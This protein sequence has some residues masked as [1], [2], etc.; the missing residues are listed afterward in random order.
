MRKGGVNKEVKT[1]D[2]KRNEKLPLYLTQL[3]LDT[4]YMECYSQWNHNCQP[5]PQGLFV[6][7]KGGGRREGGLPQ[8]RTQASSR[9]PRYKR[10]LGTE[11]EFSLQA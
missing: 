4:P 6:F 7:Q 5:R 10:R 2:N 11:S 8:P 9:Y 3:L 1:T